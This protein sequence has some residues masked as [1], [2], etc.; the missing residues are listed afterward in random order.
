[1][2]A[3]PSNSLVTRMVPSNSSGSALGS[4]VGLASGS[5]ETVASGVGVVSASCAPQ[6]AR[7]SVSAAI[8]ARERSFFFKLNT[9]GN[10]LLSVFW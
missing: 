3:R 7:E 8:S 4:A 6:A 1:M 10:D 9:S 2:L 5:R